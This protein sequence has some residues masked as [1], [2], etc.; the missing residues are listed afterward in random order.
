MDQGNKVYYPKI[1][2]NQ[3]N[4]ILMVILLIQIK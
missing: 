2:K 4:Y 1:Q 3:T